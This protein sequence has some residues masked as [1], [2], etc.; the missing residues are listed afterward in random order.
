MGNELSDA[1]TPS[2]LGVAPACAI[3]AMV[4]RHEGVTV[5][6]IPNPNP[7]PTPIPVVRLIERG[8]EDRG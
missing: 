8:D 5:T 4:A 1:P 6:L 3:T 2:L 7:N